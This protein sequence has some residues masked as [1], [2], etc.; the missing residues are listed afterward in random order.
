LGGGLAYSISLGNLTVRRLRYGLSAA[1]R[2]LDLTL[3][4]AVTPK[5]ARE[6]VVELV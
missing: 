1:A 2:Q 4:W 3:R 5:D 6:V